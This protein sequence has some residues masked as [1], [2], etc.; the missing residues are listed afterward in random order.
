MTEVAVT[1]RGAA[2]PPAAV[3][4]RKLAPRLD[5]T[6]VAALTADRCVPV[7]RVPLTP[8]GEEPS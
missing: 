7:S 3:P 6:P 1:G 8:I 4:D 5:T 2:L